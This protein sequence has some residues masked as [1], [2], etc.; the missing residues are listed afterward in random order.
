MARN[1]AGI[2]SLPAGNPVVTLTSIAS[3]WANTTMS[4]IATALTQSLA[5]T[6]VSSMTGAL[7]GFDGTVGAPGYTFSSETGSGLYR[8]GAGVIG[9]AI[10]G[11]QVATFSTAGLS[12]GA[13]TVTGSVIPVNGIYLPAANTLGFASNTLLRGS[14]N[15]T[16]NWAIVAPS[17]GVALT[18]ASTTTVATAVFGSISLG[19]NVGLL[20][21]GENIYLPGATNLGIGVVGAGGLFFYTNAI[22][23]HSIN[24]AGAHVILAPTSGSALTINGSGATTALTVSGGGFNLVAS[25]DSTAAT[26]SYIRLLNNG[27]FYAHVG[28]SNA[29]FSGT[30]GDFALYAVNNFVLGTATAG[31]IFTLASAGN[32]TLAAPNSG[33][34]FTVN[35][36]SGTH[37]MK[38]ADSAA[39]LWN[40]GF[41]E[42]PTNVQAGSYTAV[43]SDSGKNIQ[44]TA[45][46][47]KTMTI[48][49]NA[50]VAYPNGTVLVFTNTGAGVMTIAITTDTMNLSPGGTTGSR[51][52][53]QFGMATAVKQS[54]TV[55]YISG[56]GLT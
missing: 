2:Y 21:S 1:G 54:A 22:Q 34:A 35:G 45:A 17:S 43:L 40:T 4:D 16:G 8:V 49:A 20:G 42:L 50:S 11:A 18:V 7:K 48:P 10:G 33:I 53:A 19:L 41:L 37:S 26:G 31:I 9:V 52:L 25:F 39:S 38:H 47:V 13:F 5:T 14:V 56:S 46:G 44:G 24:S 55:W 32:V 36:V 6:G 27:T 29:L 30:L 23:R 28:S 3:A 12:Q 15:A 51:A